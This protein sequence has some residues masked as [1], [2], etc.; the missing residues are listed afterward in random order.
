[1][2][3]RTSTSCSE[4]AP[5]GVA[6][7]R[8][9]KN[10]TVLG[11]VRKLLPLALSAVVLAGCDSE[12]DGGETAAPPPTTTT[13]PEATAA[14][15]QSG[16][17][18]RAS[19]DPGGDISSEARGDLDGDGQEDR[20]VGWTTGGERVF[21]AATAAGGVSEWRNSNPSGAD[22]RVYG[23]AD[24]D[25]D[26]RAEVFVSPGRNAYV[27]TLVDCQ[28]TPY[29]NPQGEPYA[30]DLGTGDQGTGVGCV[31][32]DG[33]GRRDLVGLLRVPGDGAEVR[34]RRT[35]VELHGPQARNGAVSEGT[36]AAPRDDAAIAL[37]SKVTCGDQDWSA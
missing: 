18:R 28:V 27:L 30:F 9:G 29:L 6:L 2:W 12:R 23:I 20:V 15:S 35:I 3:T 8:T 22:P 21:T 37:L 17:T 36:Y 5:G 34:W 1:M 26:G 16:C 7:G 33:D 24:A 25:E 32:A 31:D 19:A 11:I 13:A 10:R 14:P 4:A